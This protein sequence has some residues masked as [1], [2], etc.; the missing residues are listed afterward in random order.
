[1]TDETE[2]DGPNGSEISNQGIDPPKKMRRDI[3]ECRD[4]SAPVTAEDLVEYRWPEDDP[5]G[6]TYMLQEQIAKFLDITSFKRKYPDIYRHSCTIEERLFLI[7]EGLVSSMVCDLGL[8]VVKSEEILDLLMQN[9]PEKYKEVSSVFQ[10]REHERMA[11][12][13][14]TCKPAYEVIKISDQGRIKQMFKKAIAS[15]HSYNSDL[16]RERLESRKYCMDMQTYT[17]HVPRK[18]KLQF[19]EKTGDIDWRCPDPYPVAVLPGQYTTSVTCFTDAQLK[20]M[21]IGT[22]LRPH[23]DTSTILFPR[24]P[25][26][27]GSGSSIEDLLSEPPAADELN[28]ESDDD[29]I[30]K[31][32]EENE[33][34]REIDA[35]EVSSCDRCGMNDE[36]ETYIT[37]SRCKK[38]AHI[39]CFDLSTNMLQTVR[40]YPWQCLD[41]KS[42]TQCQDSRNEASLLFCDICDRGFH[43]YCVGISKIPEG[44]W[45]CPICQQSKPNIPVLSKFNSPK[46]R[47]RPIDPA[48]QH[49]SDDSQPGQGSF[50]CDWVIPETGRACG[51]ILATKWMLRKHKDATLHK[52]MRHKGG[53]MY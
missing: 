25:D 35:P 6:E 2:L 24:S 34:V 22:A 29:D 17:M 52:K 5:E 47:S 49:G 36:V 23:P 30:R 13:K 3:G 39:T 44:D 12:L 33:K 15:C 28:L 9:Y 40:S 41:C 43:S 20:A 31:L 14:E 10:K 53:E 32:L 38:K 27:I 8:T 21:P 37:C 45:S 50:I 7:R 51:A 1:M 48:S 46:P 11:R 16:I 18:H 26:S 42:C 4:L 19:D